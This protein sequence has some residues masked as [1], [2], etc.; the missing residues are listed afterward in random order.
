MIPALIVLLIVIDLTYAPEQ[1]EQV[2]LVPYGNHVLGATFL[3]YN[4]IIDEQLTNT[5]DKISRRI[6]GFYY[7]RYDLRCNSI[8]D[9]KAGENFSIMEVNGARAEPAHIYEPGFSFFKAQLTIAKH[10][11]MMYEAARENHK[12]GVAYMSYKIFKDTLR[13][14]KEYRSKVTVE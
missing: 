6:D 14:R 9:L 11:R 12:N 4:H 2:V 8:E 3:N 7:G 13:L 10:F 5:I 1:G